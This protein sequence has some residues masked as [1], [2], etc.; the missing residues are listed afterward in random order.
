MKG[1]NE[2]VSSEEAARL[3]GVTSRSILNWARAGRFPGAFRTPGGRQRGGDWRIPRAAVEAFKQA[4]AGAPDTTR[5][6]AE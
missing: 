1:T 6:G 4:G 5:E 2:V 3:L